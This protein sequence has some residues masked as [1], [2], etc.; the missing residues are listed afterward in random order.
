[1]RSI[2]LVFASALVIS[3]SAPTMASEMRSM[4]PDNIEKIQ[5]MNYNL[6]LMHQKQMIEV[7][8][9]NN[10]HMKEIQE[11]NMKHT[12]ETQMMHQQMRSQR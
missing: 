11:Q 7:Q 9:L 1:M 10:R 2:T 8:E 3:F 4:Y 6:Q 12:Q 5:E